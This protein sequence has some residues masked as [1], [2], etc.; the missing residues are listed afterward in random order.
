MGEISAPHASGKCD[1]YF[2]RYVYGTV[3]SP[4][5]TLLHWC[6]VSRWR[7]FENRPA[8]ADVTNY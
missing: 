7:N 5:T 3:R 4:M 6:Q 1:K 2:T 8:F